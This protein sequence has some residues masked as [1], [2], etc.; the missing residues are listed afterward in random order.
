MIFQINFMT[1]CSFVLN[2]SKA[3]NKNVYFHALNWILNPRCS[4]WTPKSVQY[5]NS[6]SF[7][8]YKPFMVIICILKCSKYFELHKTHLI[9]CDIS[10][11]ILHQF[12][13]N[14]KANQ[15]I[16][17]MQQ[18]IWHLKRSISLCF[19]WHGRYELTF[20]YHSHSVRIV[21]PSQPNDINFTSE[22]RTFI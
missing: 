10:Q 8:M 12:V 7:Q 13:R 16:K 21:C 14:V 1:Q 15:T 2:L 20:L 17:H 18:C 22:Q 11:Y 9:I 5:R 6:N 19:Y 3:Q 4:T